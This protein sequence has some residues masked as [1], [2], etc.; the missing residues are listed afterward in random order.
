MKPNGTVHLSDIPELAR[1]WDFE[2]NISDLTPDKITVGSNRIVWW[3]CAKGHSWKDAVVKRTHGK[4]CPYCTNRRVLIGYND[5]ATLYPKLANEWDYSNNVGVDINTVVPGCTKKVS[6]KCSSC[7]HIWVASIQSR[8]RKGTGCPIC[9]K[10]VAVKHHR[11]TFLQKN[12]CLQDAKLLESWDY[13]KNAPLKPENVTASSSKSVWWKCPVCGYSWKAKVGNRTH[14][15]GCPLCSNRVLVKGVNDL[16]TCNPALA[17]EWDF[18]KNAPLT[19]ADVFPKSGRK[20]SWICPKG[21][22][23]SATVLHRA[24]GTNCPICNSGRQ[25]SFAEQAVFYYIKNLFPDAI[26]RYKDIFNNGMELDIF[27]PSKKLAIEYDGAFWHKEKNSERDRL[28]YRICQN[29]NIYL[30]RIREAAT[31][32]QGLS[33]ESFYMDN[34]DDIKNLEIL[35]QYLLDRIDPETNMWTRTRMQFHSNIHVN[36]DRDSQEIRQYMTDV[37]DSLQ[38]SYPELSAQWH[39]TK[40]GALKPSVFKCGS[41]Y[42]AW[43]LCPVCGHE[44]QASISHRVNGTGCP[45]CYRKQNKI[46]HPLAKKVYQFSKDGAFIKEWRCISEAGRSL[47]ISNSNISMCVKGKRKHAGGYIWKSTKDFD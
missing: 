17:A 34:L 39:P 44:W 23:Y 1:E 19:P 27:V 14:G 21:H 22:S 16:E 10:K 6:W 26:S 42:K 40:N 29:N 28:K 4:P 46:N 15:R 24:S 30:I 45:I 43:W 9:A 7:G 25:T 13:E 37:K 36:L 33:D 35:I 20:Y 41:D 5:L 38:T 2:K 11:E 12:G 8:T 18:T 3:R 32:S 31:Q 47:S